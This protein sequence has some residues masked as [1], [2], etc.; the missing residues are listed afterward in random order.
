MKFRITYP[1]NIYD[2][3]GHSKPIE[4][5]IEADDELEAMHILLEEIGLLNYICVE[6]IK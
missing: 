1:E 6:E 3:L 5:E 2:L 4:E